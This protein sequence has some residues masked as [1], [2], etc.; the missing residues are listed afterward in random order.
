MNIRLTKFDFNIFISYTF[1]LSKFQ[2]LTRTKINSFF[3]MKSQIILLLKE[4][5]TDIISN[6]LFSGND[7]KHDEIDL[8]W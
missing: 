6:V 7:T 3:R 5:G 4:T 8:K 1:T 2:S